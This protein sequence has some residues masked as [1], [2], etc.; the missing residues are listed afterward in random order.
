MELA[1]GGKPGLW[2]PTDR[3]PNEPVG[4]S[5]VDRA[6]R[7]DGRARAEL[8]GRLADVWYRY[9][10]SMLR[11]ADAARDAAQESAL[12][13]LARLEAFRGDSSVETFAIG[14]AVNVCREQRRQRTFEACE[15]PDA[16]H[17][18]TP[19]PDQHAQ[20]RE[21]RDRICELVATLPQ[22]QRE[23]VVLR[24]FEQL[25]LAEVAEAMGC[26][27]GTV[28]ATLAQALRALRNRWE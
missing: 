10:L 2:R 8:L 15:Q 19:R 9:C 26:A 11:D 20:R 6:K 18:D 4:S 24:Y 22:R 7:G 14:I 1:I 23:A 13:F 3:A 25:P 21:A 16:H 12:R 17:A 5:V 28:K 27:L